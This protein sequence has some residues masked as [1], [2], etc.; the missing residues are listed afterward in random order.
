VIC[1]NVPDLFDF[2]EPGLIALLKER[3]TPHLART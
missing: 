3:V 2:M 1:L